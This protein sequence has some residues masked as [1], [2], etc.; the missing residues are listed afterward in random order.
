[1]RRND[2]GECFDLQFNCVFFCVIMQK[3]NEFVFSSS[4][5]LSGIFYFHEN[6]LLISNKHSRTNFTN[7][8]PPPPPLVYKTHAV[9]LLYLESENTKKKLYSRIRLFE[10]FFFKITKWIIPHQLSSYNGVH[11]HESFVLKS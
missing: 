3:L 5:S 6:T 11:Y 4:F 10:D 1:M 9:K 7:L 2:A 8:L